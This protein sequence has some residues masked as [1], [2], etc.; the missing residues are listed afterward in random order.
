MFLQPIREVNML[1]GDLVLRMTP[2]LKEEASR[3]TVRA[4]G[5]AVARGGRR[6]GGRGGRGGGG[7]GAGAGDADR[8][9]SRNEINDFLLAENAAVLIDRGSDSTTPAGGSNL[10]WATQRTDGGTIFPG[11]G[12]PRDENAGNVVPSATIAVEHYNR[13]MRIL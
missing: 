5:G 4:T 12:G 13:M 2:E 1:E 9:L 6:G 3:T 8:R 11:G 10:S 7:G